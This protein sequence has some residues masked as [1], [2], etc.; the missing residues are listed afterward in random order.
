VGLQTGKYT[1]VMQA[2]RNTEKRMKQRN[3]N[4]TRTEVQKIC[5]NKG[6]KKKITIKIK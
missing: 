5:K 2:I 3:L 6:R 4:D 1:H